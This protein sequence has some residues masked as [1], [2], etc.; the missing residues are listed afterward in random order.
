MK[1]IKPKKIN[2]GVETKLGVMTRVHATLP[3]GYHAII[4]EH[5]EAG[6]YWQIKLRMTLIHD[7]YSDS[8]NEAKENCQSYWDKM[9]LEAFEDVENEDI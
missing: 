4:R 6:W 9:L 8:L 3:L 5:G 1:A 7:E 2:W